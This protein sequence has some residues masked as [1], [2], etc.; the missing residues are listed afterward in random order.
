MYRAVWG[1]TAL[2]AIALGRAEAGSSNS[3][4]D[5]T[6][7]GALLLV[8]N[9]DNGT[10]TVVDVQKRAKLREIPVGD[11]PEGVTW[12][13]NGPLALVTVY[14]EDKVVFVDTTAGTAVHTLGVDDEPYGIVANRSGSRAWVTHDYPGSVSEIDI[15]SKMV[16]RKIKADE[17]R[18]YVTEFYT[19]KLHAIDLATG[20]VVDTWVGRKTENLSRNVVVH[21]KRPKAY[22]AHTR[23]VTD[24]ISSRGS[25][26]PHLTVCDLVPPDA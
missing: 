7:D 13:G 25:V 21:P 4:M 1:I 10:V 9:F 26:F 18:L 22:L 2:A 3:L 23:S 20:A 11:K 8:A 15:N 19:S 14:R 6:P 17:S 16:T 5:I 24:V 12:V